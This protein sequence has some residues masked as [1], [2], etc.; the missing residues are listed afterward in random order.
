[1][2]GDEMLCNPILKCRGGNL[3]Q[4]TG[5]GIFRLPIRIVLRESKVSPFITRRKKRL[6]SF[7]TNSS[8]E[9]RKHPP[10]NQ[11]TVTNTSRICSRPRIGRFLFTSPHHTCHL[12]IL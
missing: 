8:V 5:L 9:Q 6:N 3:L 4:E 7:S 1:M 2:D 12:R 10:H 11:V